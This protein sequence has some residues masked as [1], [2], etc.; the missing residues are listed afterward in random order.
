MYVLCAP[1]T[2]T[3][4]LTCNFALQFYFIRH[5]KMQMNL[6]E[7]ARWERRSVLWWQYDKSQ[8]VLAYS[9]GRELA[10]FLRFILLSHSL[11]DFD[12][13]WSFM[14]VCFGKCFANNTVRVRTI[15]GRYTLIKLNS[16]WS[17][18]LS[19]SS[20]SANRPHVMWLQRT[21]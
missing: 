17:W 11:N 1:F 18:S 20:N 3:K 14:F 19:N 15:G 12:R 21:C 8:V 9:F 4:V 6:P 16:T 10:R 2:I 5:A 7:L 13:P